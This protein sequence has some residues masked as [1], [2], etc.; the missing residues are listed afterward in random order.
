[1]YTVAIIIPEIKIHGLEKT[2][3]RKTNIMAF[4]TMIKIYN[5]NIVHFFFDSVN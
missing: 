1:M 5:S 4:S 3:W 2:P